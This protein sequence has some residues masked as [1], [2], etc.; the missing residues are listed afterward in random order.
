MTKINCIFPDGSIRAVPAFVQ[1][2]LGF[3]Y[4]D[5][6]EV[7]HPEAEPEKDIDWDFLK[8][9]MPHKGAQWVAI[10]APETTEGKNA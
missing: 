8:L 9:F 7:I 3:D 4:P 2:P 5:N 6:V 1:I 10:A